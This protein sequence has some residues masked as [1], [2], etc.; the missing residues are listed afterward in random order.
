MFETLEVKGISIGI[1]TKFY[2]N[3][4]ETL[5]KIWETKEKDFMNLPGIQEKTS[6]KL[7]QSIHSSI[8]KP[9]PLEKIMTMSLVFGNGFAEKKFKLIVDEIPNILDIYKSITVDR[10]T[11]IDGFSDKTAT[12]FVEKLP[13]FIDFLRNHNFLKVKDTSKKESFQVVFSGFRD[14]DLKDAIEELGG[15]VLDGINSKTNILVVKDKEEE[16]TGK[17]KK[18][19]KFGTE[20]ITK[21][22]F[23]QKYCLPVL[24]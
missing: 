10:I 17:V 15:K 14:K 23:I 5:G 2:E 18:A 11:D 13:L 12:V 21:E 4:L 8:D 22:E 9:L 16:P 7:F 20:I 3:S 24:P 6:K 19:I 1:V